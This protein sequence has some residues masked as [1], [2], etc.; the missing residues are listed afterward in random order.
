M[1]ANQSVTVLRFR[2]AYSVAY[3]LLNVA[4]PSTVA[5]KDN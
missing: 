2:V 1:A 4:F 5:N 3:S